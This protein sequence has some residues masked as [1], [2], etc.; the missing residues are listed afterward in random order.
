MKKLLSLVVALMM[1]MPVF[2]ASHTMNYQAVINNPDG[3]IAANREIGLKFCF[4]SDSVTLLTEEAT[5]MSNDQGL[6]EYEIGSSFIHGLKYINWSDPDLKLQVWIDPNGGTAYTSAYSSSI[7]AVPR[8]LYAEKSGDSAIIDFFNT[9]LEEV[10]SLTYQNESD[11]KKNYDQILYNRDNLTET[12]ARV[13]SLEY[14]VKFL[15]NNVDS[16]KAASNDGIKIRLDELQNQIY[17]NMDSIASISHKIANLEIGNGNIDKAELD[18]Q[19]QYLHASIVDNRAVIE[20]LRQQT[21]YD[22]DSIRSQM[23]TK[24]EVAAEL[25]HINMLLQKMEDDLK[26]RIDETVQMLASKVDAEIIDMK[27]RIEDTAKGLIQ[28]Y[29]AMLMDELDKQKKDLLDMINMY[30]DKNNAVI[31]DTLEKQNEAITVLSRRLDGIEGT[32][33]YANA[34]A[35]D[36]FSLAQFHDEYIIDLKKENEELKGEVAALKDIVN[37]LQQKV[38]ELSNK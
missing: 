31:A 24:Q 37:V 17:I 28:D 9:K 16:I 23:L 4:I 15:N 19:L 27:I 29:S 30:I 5:V 6:V 1:T 10:Q 21:L 33:N 8:A 7:Q 26:I 14:N 35:A 32:A 38:E 20:Q 34:V 25:A 11:I 12:T 18:A 22:L 36:A 3:T 13:T 2:A